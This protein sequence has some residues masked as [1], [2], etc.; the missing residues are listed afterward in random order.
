[1]F[2]LVLGTSIAYSLSSPELDDDAIKEW[3][4]AFFYPMQLLMMTFFLELASFMRIVHRVVAVRYP[5]CDDTVD[6]AM[7]GRLLFRRSTWTGAIWA[8]TAVWMMHTRVKAQ[9]R[10]LPA[11]HMIS[12]AS[13]FVVLAC[14]EYKAMALLDIRGVVD[15]LMSPMVSTSNYCATHSMEAATS[16]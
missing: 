9:V 10:G 15:T 8:V 2:A 16:G 11:G 6:V 5:T 1:M 13:M 7:C 4:R 3:A 12:W 14:F